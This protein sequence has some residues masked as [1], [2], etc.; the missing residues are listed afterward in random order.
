MKK[1]VAFLINALNS[2]GAER[3]MSI[4][5]KELPKYEDMD[6][7]LILLE[8]VIEYEL[9]KNLK[10]TILSNNGENAMKNTLFIPLYTYKLIRYLKREKIDLIVSFLC[11]A[12]Y[13]NILASKITGIKSAISIRVNNTSA[14]MTPS[15][16]SKINK[17][18]IKK[19]FPSS[20]LVIN[21]SQGTLEDMAENFGVDRKNQIVIYNPY[22]MDEILKASKESV[23]FEIDYDNTVIAVSRFRPVKNLSLLIEAFKE[24]D[25]KYKLLLVG[26]GVEREKLERLTDTFKLR[27]RIK[28]VGNDTNP[29]KYMSKCSIYISLSKAEGFPNALVEAMICG[30]APISTDCPS[31]PREILSPGSDYS[32]KLDSGIEEAE[33]GVLVAVDDKEATIEALRLLLNNK[34]KREHYSLKA[35]ERAKDFHIDSIVKEY[36]DTLINHMES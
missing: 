33:Y 28:F 21:V 5:L 9:P 29:Y 10:V 3:V 23:D 11:R 4:L 13:V 15:L 18:L 24:L 14:Y 6:V 25:K 1:R 31:G 12:N 26:D 32:K 36:R 22:D 19:L 8:N 35:K 17:F 27:D 7:E 2:G 34:T 30:C 20:P 16:S